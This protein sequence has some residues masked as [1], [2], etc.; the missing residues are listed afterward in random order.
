VA[1]AVSADR[2]AALFEVLD[3]DGTEARVREALAAEA[4]DEGRAEALTQLARVASWRDRWDEAAALLDEA[5]ALAGETGTARARVLLERGRL[6]H[7]AG[8]DAG[9]LA[10]LEQAYGAARAARASFVAADAAHSC[11]LLGDMEAWT[12]RG[13]ELA[14][15]DPAARY[16]RGTLLVNLGERQWERGEVDAS[17]VSFRAALAAREHEKRNPSLTEE[18][19][20]GVARAL[21]ALGRPDEAIPLLEQVGRWVDATGFGLP[22]ADAWRAELD[23]ARSKTPRTP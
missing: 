10:L 3:V 1:T 5:D 2:F 4:T 17:L 19:R 22:E 15:G 12:K 6:A 18:A 20:A 11:A 16:W 7:H 21:C 13:L 14:E 23:I 9:A 8:D